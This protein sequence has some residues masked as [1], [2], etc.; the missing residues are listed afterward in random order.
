V[1]I[2]Q[3]AAFFVPLG[4]HR[5][6]PLASVALD[7]PH[8]LVRLAEGK[9][10]ECRPGTAFYAAVCLVVERMRANAEDDILKNRALDASIARESIALLAARNAQLLAS[11]AAAEARR[12]VG[13][14][15]GKAKGGGQG[16]GEGASGAHASGAH[17]SGTLFGD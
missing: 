10:A 15:A 3:A 12:S 7:S 16:V 4:E 14:G 9:A 6:R 11:A 5:H 8:Y 17:A 1:N 2:H 13:R